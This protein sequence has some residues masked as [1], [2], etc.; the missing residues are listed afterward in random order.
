MALIFKF[1]ESLKGPTIE[2]IKM[3]SSYKMQSS[4]CSCAILP[5]MSRCLPISDFH[6]NFNDKVARFFQMEAW[7]SN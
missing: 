6:C 2:I 1:M 5:V 3:Q 7:N 4:D